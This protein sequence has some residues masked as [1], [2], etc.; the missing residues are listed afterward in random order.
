MEFQVA[1]NIAVSL[2]GLLGGWVLKY[3]TDELKAL[4]NANEKMLEKIQHVE[5]LVAGQYVRND[6]LERFSDA[7]FK[8]LDR[9]EQR[10]YDGSGSPSI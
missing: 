3:I 6:A 8:K 2:V 4:R 9:I 1:F 10:I 7:V 5:V